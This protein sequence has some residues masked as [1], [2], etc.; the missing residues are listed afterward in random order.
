M[1]DPV[2]EFDRDPDP[3]QADRRRP[4]L[5]YWPK[6]APQPKGHESHVEDD[7]PLFEIPG[8]QPAH[9]T[10]RGKYLIEAPD[11]LLDRMGRLSHDESQK[12]SS[13]TG[14]HRVGVTAG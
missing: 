14:H 7:K 4:A 8:N 12:R 3:D 13:K 11:I 9:E 1:A 5:A 2:Q 10:R 6:E